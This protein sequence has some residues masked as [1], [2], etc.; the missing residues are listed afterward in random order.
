MRH[1]LVGLRPSGDPDVFFNGA[2]QA[3]RRTDEIVRA[4]HWQRIA[5][6]YPAGI[7]F[8]NMDTNILT[9]DWVFQKGQTWDSDVIGKDVKQGAPARFSRN[10]PLPVVAADGELPFVVAGKFPNGAV[11]I[12]TFG[13]VTNG[14]DWHTPLADIT[15]DVDGAPGPF[16]VFGHYKSLT[17]KLGGEPGHVVRFLCQDLAGERSVDITRQVIVNGDSVTLPGS[18]IDRMGVSAG[19]LGDLSDP[20]VVLAIQRR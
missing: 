17:L 5:E 4:L 2:R 7:G 13:R 8:V 12:A 14:S 20:G 9:D 10:L 15:V 6:P 18:L 1:P 19:S 16:G 3:K 11:G